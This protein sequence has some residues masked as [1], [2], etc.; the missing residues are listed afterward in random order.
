MV[1]NIWFGWKI[2][3]KCDLLR[4]QK[5]VNCIIDHINSLDIEYCFQSGT[6]CGVIKEFYINQK[7]KGT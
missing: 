7:D 3:C 4:L 5:Y 2:F 1:L 6:N